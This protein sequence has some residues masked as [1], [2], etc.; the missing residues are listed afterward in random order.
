MVPENCLIKK[1]SWSIVSVRPVAFL[2]GFGSIATLML[3]KWIAATAWIALSL[4]ACDSA[5]DMG[6]GRDLG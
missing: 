6:V 2:I 5:D 1:G 3:R 4:F